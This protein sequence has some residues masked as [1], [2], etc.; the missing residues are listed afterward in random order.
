MQPIRHVKL[1]PRINPTAKLLDIEDMD[2]VG[3]VLFSIRYTSLLIINQLHI[4]FI[5]LYFEIIC[6]P[7]IL[8]LF[9][10]AEKTRERLLL[11]T[12]TENV[13]S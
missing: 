13:K 10:F 1:P 5:Y 9:F 11:V 3:F 8:A 2:P 4:I 7:L 6:I 12:V